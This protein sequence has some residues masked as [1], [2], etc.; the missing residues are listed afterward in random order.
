VPTEAE[1]EMAQKRLMRR[2]LWFTL[3]A[4]L[5]VVG[6][7]LLLGFASSNASA[8]T[9]IW[10]GEDAG[11]LFSTDANWRIWGGANDV[12]PT[13]GDD[14]KFWDW[15]DACTW[16]VALTVGAITLGANYSGTVTQG[17]VPFGCNN[18]ERYA[19]TFT[20]SGVLYP[21]TVSGNWN[22]VASSYSCSVIMTGA[23]KTLASSNY[24]GV[25]IEVGASVTAASNVVVYGTNCIFHVHGTYIP[26][27]TATTVYAS[28]ADVIIDGTIQGTAKL[29]LT[30]HV[31]ANLAGI[32]GTINCPV[33]F[34]IDAGASKTISLIRDQA[35]GNSIIV[36]GGGV[37]VTLTVDETGYSLSATSVTAST[38]G[39]IS[40]S[41]AGAKV[42]TTGAITVSANG[43]L[44]ATNI[45]WI[46]CGTNWDSSAGTWKPGVNQVN[47]TATG[48]TKLA[49]GQTFYN[50]LAANGGT[51]RTLLSNVV[52]TNH[53]RVDGALAQGA[54]SVTVSGSN[55]KPLEINGTTSG[56]IAITSSAA[57]Y[58]IYTN[59]AMGAGSV[60]TTKECTFIFTGGQTTVTPDSGTANVSMK[61][62]TGTNDYRWYLGETD[63]AAN[64]TFS[65]PGMTASG[66]YDL[67]LDGANFQ[68]F[69]ANGAG[70]LAIYHATWSGHTMTLVFVASWAPTITSS[71]ATTC[72]IGVSYSYT[73]TTNESSTFA[74]ITAPGWI[75]WSSPSYSGPPVAAGVFAFHVQATSVAGTL[76]ADQYWNVTVYAIPTITNTASLSILIY[77]TYYYNATADQPGTWSITESATWL[78]ESTYHLTGMADRTQLSPVLVHVSLANVNG[79]AYY[80]FT[81]T[82][83]GW[84]ATFTTTAPTVLLIGETYIYYPQ[85]NV[86]TTLSVITYPAWMSLVG[87]DHL[88]GMGV[89]PGNYS[90][91][92]RTNCS[93]GLY[94][95]QNYTVSVF[96]SSMVLTNPAGMD[97]QQIMFIV[98][99]VLL[100]AVSF[101]DK[102]VM[103]LGGML[104]MCGSLFVWYDLYSF[105]F[106]IGIGAGLYFLLNGAMEY[107]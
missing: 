33:N 28:M 56:V 46:S 89:Y 64:V 97:V 95:Y 83:Y 52:V 15:D 60:S 30:F 12:E 68:T 100:T 7:F 47:M 58:T 87:G 22:G 53:K 50:L 82:P 1:L 8:D 105:M 45:A 25:Q 74:S 102:R 70:V 84:A 79:T 104:W 13:A 99:L 69:H 91:S 6:L 48:T 96:A 11:A 39:I 26:G 43:Q 72:S 29:S 44:D 21:I 32:T 34:G 31:S 101:L 20:G 85:S 35:F 10:D 36:V 24:A 63:G 71:P 90:I 62:W 61:S 51:T 93:G 38:R 17:A 73:V 18:F 75:V 42:T 27:G 107:V 55:A 98:M 59:V 103:F 37:G 66:R 76:T 106:Y 54:Y 88:T 2:Y 65:I 78:T 19:G 49:G 5:F 4:L 16:D 77:H 81:V 57:S 92:I 94:A 14:I 80:N 41:V 3:L 9:H 67:Y 23:G 40:S 86:T